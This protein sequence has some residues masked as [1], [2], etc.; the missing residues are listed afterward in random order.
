MNVG[1]ALTMAKPTASALPVLAWTVACEEFSSS[2]SRGKALDVSRHTCFG[3]ERGQHDARGSLHDLRQAC[4]DA[5]LFVGTGG[6]TS[7]PPGQPT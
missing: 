4:Q 1:E 7:A 2:N 3:L 6:S 5:L